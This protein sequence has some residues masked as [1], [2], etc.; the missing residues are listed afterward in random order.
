ML[1]GSVCVLLALLTFPSPVF[2]E[3]SCA[4]LEDDTYGH[5]CVWKVWVRTEGFLS[6]YNTETW[7]LENVSAS[8]WKMDSN[9]F[10]CIQVFITLYRHSGWITIFL[11][12]A[13]L[14][15]VRGMPK[16]S[17]WGRQWRHGDSETCQSWALA[18]K[19]WLWMMVENY[20]APPWDYCCCNSKTYAICCLSDCISDLLLSC[21]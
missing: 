12:F 13:W 17:L 19:A 16:S 8:F 10:S 4:A 9:G 15:E 5:V 7:T 18:W 1:Q 11:Q 21:V 3:S 20:A 14:R 2:A 6:C